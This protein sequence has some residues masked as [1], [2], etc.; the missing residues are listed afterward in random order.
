MAR[1]DIKQGWRFLFECVHS[2]TWNLEQEKTL[3]EL[4]GLIL[5]V[6]RN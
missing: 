5:L 6:G 4:T 2:Y 1:K 3:H